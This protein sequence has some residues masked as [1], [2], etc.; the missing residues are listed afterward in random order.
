MKRT[1]GYRCV[2]CGEV[3]SILQKEH[4]V[5]L[6]R[7]GANNAA[8]IVPACPT[9]NYRKGSMTDE[10]FRDRLR[11]EKERGTFLPRPKVLR[12][13]PEFWRTATSAASAG[14]A[15]K[16]RAPSKRPAPSSGG[17]R[18]SGCGEV[19][20]FSDFG[21]NRSR[22]DGLNHACKGCVRAR[23]AAYKARQPDA[24]QAAQRKQR[25]NQR[26][27][28]KAS[29]FVADSKRCRACG[30]EKPAAEF[31]LDRGRQDGLQR[32]CKACIAAGYTKS[33]PGPNA[34]GSAEGDTEPV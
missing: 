25:Q 19:L 10:E 15:P 6:S 31:H 13:A 30:V 16:A 4:R 20:P 28:A 14:T 8:N 22:P 34:H 1:A 23:S 27:R 5:P 17:K 2:Y 7:G 11:A 18:C 26:E 33:A 9:C 29:G 24:Y 21:T 32:R 3:S 12:Q